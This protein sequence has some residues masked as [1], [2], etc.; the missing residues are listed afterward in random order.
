MVPLQGTH[1]RSDLTGNKTVSDH[2]SKLELPC[3]M[4]DRLVRRLQVLAA[5]GTIEIVNAHEF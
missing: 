3:S 4:P 2:L 1:C 5:T